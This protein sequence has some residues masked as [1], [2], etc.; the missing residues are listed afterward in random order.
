[1][2]CVNHP[3]KESSALCNH[4][5]KP[6]CSECLVLVKAENYC[7]DCI[8]KKFGREKQEEHSPALA[9]L[10]SF[11]IGGLGQVYNGQVGKAALI[12]FTSWL[13]V[14]WIIGIFDA[15]NVARRIKSGQ[16]IKTAHNGCVIAAALGAAMFIF[17]G[18]FIT[19]IIVA[20]AVPNLILARARANESFARAT[21]L[22]VSAKAES[23]RIEN[24]KYPSGEYI[25]SA[26]G[27][28]FS[29]SFKDGKYTITARPQS[30][31]KTGEKIFIVETGGVVSSRKCEK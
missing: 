15:Y 3:E 26:R 4:C 12:F 29:Q 21:V 9:A 11:I 8:E 19:A 25:K 18:I 17:T 24:G 27:Y 7:K 20:I 10:L 5:G 14:P 16:I 23:Y 13:I 28:L 2:K 31:G 30:C 1:M 22:S 6:I